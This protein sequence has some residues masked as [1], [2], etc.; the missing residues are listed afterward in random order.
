MLKFGF[1]LLCA[2]LIISG[3][4]NAVD[5]DVPPFPMS[6]GNSISTSMEVPPGI[7][8]E[9]ETTVLNVSP[10]EVS[11]QGRF[12][13]KNTGAAV[14]IDLGFRHP[15]ANGKEESGGSP[16]PRFVDK[17]Q[18]EEMRDFKASVDS[19]PVVVKDKEVTQTLKVGL[20][21]KIVNS[22]WKTWKLHF[23]KGQSHT[24]DVS[25]KNT[26]TT[27]N[28]GGPKGA[29]TVEYDFST[30]NVWKGPVSS[31]NIEIN[32]IGMN[33]SKVVGIS[34]APGTKSDT[35]Y[36]WS[37]QNL[38]KDSNFNSVLRLSFKDK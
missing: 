26:P 10:K 33:S 30:N 23:D 19:K 8:L 16:M 37:T 31:R 25:Y 22:Y 3:C 14:D 20:P 27:E 36:S 24:I 4:A 1:N 29:K 7:H 5:A 32:L 38:P 12:V 9:S 34:P 13:L 2:T 17:T 28:F 35:R 21:G 15:Y 18:A 6:G 11:V